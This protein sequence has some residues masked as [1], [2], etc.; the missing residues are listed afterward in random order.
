MRKKKVD[1]ESDS[2]NTKY[3]GDDLT[4]EGKS[5]YELICMTRDYLRAHGI[6]LFSKDITIDLCNCPDDLESH[7][8]IVNK[9]FKYAKYIK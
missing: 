7:T 3:H 5:K 6:F 9:Y 1:E 8:K 4:I 2:F